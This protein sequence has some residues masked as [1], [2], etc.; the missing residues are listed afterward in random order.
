MTTYV[1][2]TKS[3]PHLCN[4]FEKLISVEADN[5]DFGLD[6]LYLAL[7]NTVLYYK[8]A[9]NALWLVTKLVE[10]K[11]NHIIDMTIQNQISTFIWQNTDPGKSKNNK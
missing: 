4:C 3:G 7:R 8:V 6:E 11:Y 2:R 9:Q 1:T 10:K 5:A